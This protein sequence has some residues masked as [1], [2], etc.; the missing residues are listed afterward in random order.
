MTL[1]CACRCADRAFRSLLSAAIFV[2]PFGRIADEFGRKKIFVAG[3]LI[4][5]VS[6][7]LCS[8]SSSIYML[9]ASRAVEG[10][11]S[12]MIFGT[13]VA[14]LTSVT[15]PDQR[16]KALGIYTTAV[17]LGLSTGPFLGGILT[18]TVLAVAR[19][20]GE[21][22]PLLFT[23]SLYANAVTTDPSQPL[24]SLPVTIFI[25]SEAPDKTLN[26]QAWAAVARAP[27]SS[28]PGSSCSRDS[29]SET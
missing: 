14:I 9:I 19:A 10:V 18:G 6:S 4:V 2:V 11:G 8:V 15:P 23:S 28:R 3:L 27:S 26:D 13:A 25:Y 24:P 20:A 21:T 22:A 5:A 7:L 29:S 16:G 12:A 1:C 17:Y